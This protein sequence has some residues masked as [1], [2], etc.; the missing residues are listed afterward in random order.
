MQDAGKVVDYYIVF[1]K[2][3]CVHWLTRFLDSQIQHCYAVGKSSG[4]RFWKV[5]EP[6]VNNLAVSLKSVSQYPSIRDI[7]GDEAV[8]VRVKTELKQTKPQIRFC[9]RSCVEVVKSLL[10]IQRAFIITPRQLYIYLIK[11]ELICK[12]QK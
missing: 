3:K 5:I 9:L 8:I 4:G 2:T 6:G 7:A 12:K 10:G 1:E 11:E